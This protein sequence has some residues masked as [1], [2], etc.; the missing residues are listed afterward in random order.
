[1]TEHPAAPTREAVIARGLTTTSRWSGRF[2]LIAAA[3]VVLGL[4]VQVAWSVL[5]PVVLALVLTTVLEPPTRLLRERAHFPA[6]LAAATVLLGGLLVLVG[7]GFLLAPAVAG[8]SGDIVDD[9]TEGLQ[10]LQDWVQ[11]SDFLTKDQ[12]D[13][14]IQSLQ[15]KLSG[16]G[17][18]I[19]S[20]VLSGVGVVGNLVVTAVVTLVLVFLFLKDGRR[21]LPLVRRFAGARA[22][23]HLAEVMS[24]SWDTLG[25]YIRTQALVSLIDAVLIGIA[26]VLVGVPLAI[27]LA[28]LTF[29]G[30]F[31]PIVGAVVAGS[32]AVLVALVSNGPTGALIVLG[33]VLA[34]QQLEGNVLSP[35]LQAKSMDLHA[36][37][38]LLSVT[39]GGTLFGIVGAF[40]AVPVAAVGAVVIRYLDEQVDRASRPGT[41]SPAPDPAER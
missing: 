6:A 17:G 31:I 2:L 10:Q 14:G 13:S 23:G 30:G 33:V 5:L 8:Q 25:G 7:L 24:R 12:I 22:G 38:V 4:L 1:V 39:L 16:S 9:A 21:F 37:V 3:A 41:S 29:L 32:L 18:A 15:E 11:S 28:L 36:A 40:L 26:L 27:P 20:G 19:A 34:V 35:W